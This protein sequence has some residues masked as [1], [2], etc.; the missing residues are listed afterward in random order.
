MLPCPNPFLF[1]FYLLLSGN[2]QGHLH[3]DDSSVARLE[4]T[5]WKGVYLRAEQE[6]DRGAL[7]EMDANGNEDKKVRVNGVA[8]IRACILRLWLDEEDGMRHLRATC[9]YYPASEGISPIYLSAQVSKPF[10]H[11][12]FI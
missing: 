3:V 11:V 5:I 7:A 10:S 12:I 1:L 4:M 6:G 2:W 9:S 8:E